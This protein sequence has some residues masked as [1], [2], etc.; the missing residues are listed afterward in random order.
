M[1]APNENIA[2]RAGWY[3]TEGA[4]TSNGWNGS[5]S[6]DKITDLVK[7]AKSA[8]GEKDREKAWQ[9]LQTALNEGS[10]FI[11]LAV[12]GANIASSPSITDAKYDL[13]NSIDYTT[14]R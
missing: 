3:T 10:P 12:Q 9:D 1:F 7:A 4:K 6:A 8:S 14:M 13:L 2:K 5:A 11:P